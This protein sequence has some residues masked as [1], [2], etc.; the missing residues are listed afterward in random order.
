LLALVLAGLLLGAA[1][2]QDDGYERAATAFGAGDPR[3]ARVAL[4]GA[5]DANP[6]DG[7]ALLLLG[8]VQLALGDGL[9]AEAA[10]ARARGVGVPARALGPYLAHA[11]LLQGRNDEAVAA[12]DPDSV[13]PALAPDAWRVR[14]Q[15]QAALGRVQAAADSFDTALGIAP[16]DHETWIAVA[17]FRLANG[18]M[19]GAQAA[20]NRAVALAPAR[21]EALVLKGELARTQYGLLAALPWFD[22]ALAI[23]P[24][25]VSALMGR[26]ATLGEAGRTQAMLADTRA[27]LALVPGHARAYYLQAV[28]A[29]RAGRYRLARRLLQ[30]TEDAFADEPAAMLLQG[31]V[32]QGAGAPE[33]AIDVLTRL[34]ALQPDNIRARRVL[35]A[36]QWRAGDVAGTIDTLR[37][38]AERADAD[39]YV[40]TLFARALERRGRR[41][42]AASYL[43]RAALPRSVR[44]GRLA[45]AD[46]DAVDA[47]RAAGGDGGAGARIG[48]IRALAESGDM[49]AAIDEA[50]A[51]AADNPGAPA[52]HVVLGDV[53][54]VAGLGAQAAAQYRR[55][56]NISFTEPVALRMIEAYR[57]IGQDPAAIEALDIFLV[58][59]PE[60]VPARLLGAEILIQSGQW[61][62]AE[63][64]LDRVRRRIGPR[65]AVMLNNLAWAHA[66]LGGG[67]AGA[68]LAARARALIP[69]NPA[70]TDSAAWLLL[71]AGGSHARA[72][73][74]LR[75]ATLQTPTAWGPAWHLAEAYSR[76]GR[77]DLARAVARL[78]LSRPGFPHAAAARRMV[79]RAG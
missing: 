77:A 63:A 76:T 75:Q 21:P 37:G 79:A 35:A 58:Q 2:P 50:S 10:L 31:V 1:P 27:V 29:A 43:D 32:E 14:G 61:A 34:I 24:D 18:E 62:R 20:A 11:L 33:Q 39:T 71:Q 17:R 74:L 70:L 47:A 26:A 25:D 73:A 44:G 7:R 53:L 28:L 5:I 54:D 4:L 36:A 19:A 46:A 68:G 72:I 49:A 60:N 23:R 30:L 78:A 52:A 65:D 9:A 41:D 38:A 42:L 69:A 51:L 6:R 66:R 55:A 22:R 16:A 64:M 15:A 56:A 59:N 45:R 3:T 12:V 8:R 13:A 57:R 40:L 48:V 67:V